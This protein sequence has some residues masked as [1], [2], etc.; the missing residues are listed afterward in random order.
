MMFYKTTTSIYSPKLMVLKTKGKH[1]T[2]YSRCSK[3]SGDPF[4]SLA[5]TKDF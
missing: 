5:S 3:V 2:F 1:N 4:T